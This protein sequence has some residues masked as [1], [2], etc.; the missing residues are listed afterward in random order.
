MTRKALF[1]SSV[2]LLL[3][4]GRASAQVGW[5]VEWGVDL[6]LI[7]GD[8]I[9]APAEGSL[10]YVKQ[11]LG[12][13]GN[14][15]ITSDDVWEARACAP[16]VLALFPKN[17][18]PSTLAA[19]PPTPLLGGHTYGLVAWPRKRQP[20]VL[21]P[22]RT[23]GTRLS[24]RCFHGII[25]FKTETPRMTAL[26]IQS[27]MTALRNLIQRWRTDA[28]RP[29]VPRPLGGVLAAPPPLPGVTAAA[30]AALGA[31]LGGCNNTF[32][33]VLRLPY[34]DNHALALAGG[35]GH[36]TKHW[37]V[38]ITNHNNVQFR[39]Q[40]NLN[41]PIRYFANLN[42]AGT[43]PA[44]TNTFVNTQ[45]QELWSDTLA[46]NFGY[47]LNDARKGFYR[48]YGW[49][50]KRMDELA[51]ARRVPVTQHHVAQKNA[52]N[53]NIKFDF[54]ALKDRFNLV[55]GPLNGYYGDGGSI[56]R[57]ANARPRQVLRNPVPGGNDCR[58]VT[59]DVTLRPFTVGG[60]AR[61]LFEFRHPGANQACFDLI[62]HVATGAGNVANL[63]AQCH[64][65][66]SVF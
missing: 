54:C 56:Y 8:G 9:A 62:D 58:F 61:P 23:P 60:H 65:D 37:Y 12:R 66:T 19:D 13:E 33:C 35:P 24:D 50:A 45:F 14:W 6:M 17:A 59:R 20:P 11:T 25:E 21:V 31:G 10:F 2:L 43:G 39:P 55:D 42:N 38:V 44:S 41:I 7:E 28:V 32:P 22:G 27:D 51:A 16:E 57:V 1:L 53:P 4:S 18:P 64:T 47:V 46:W 15:L 3:L 34:Y 30:G 63:A 40:V 49:Y 52:L 5:E 36:L 29:T 48:L 26:D